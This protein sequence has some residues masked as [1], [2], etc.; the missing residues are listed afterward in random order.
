MGEEL[1]RSIFNLFLIILL[2]KESTSLNR[3]P[4]HHWSLAR[5]NKREILKYIQEIFDKR[6]MDISA[7][8]A[9]EIYNRKPESYIKKILKYCKEHSQSF[10]I[11]EIINT[12]DISIEEK[13]SISTA[14][15]NTAM[16]KT[17]TKKYWVQEKTYTLKDSYYWKLW[18]E[19]EVLKVLNEVSDHFDLK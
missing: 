3:A 4:I 5:K 14:M 19:K 10:K 1:L 16:F 8:I 18:L 6:K 13:R 9:I 15:R 11:I 12:L 17:E 2:M 7:E